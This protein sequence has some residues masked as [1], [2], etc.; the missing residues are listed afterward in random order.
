MLRVIAQ[1]MIHPVGYFITFRES[2]NKT[3]QVGFFRLFPVY[4][5]YIPGTYLSLLGS[6]L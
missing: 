3:L 1:N 6:Q 2:Q 4:S 5:Y